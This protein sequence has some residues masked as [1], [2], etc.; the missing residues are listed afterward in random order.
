MPLFAQAGDNTHISVAEKHPGDFLAGI[1]PP[2]RF[3][4]G[5][6]PLFVLLALPAAAFDLKADYGFHD[7]VVPEVSSHTFG[8]NA[9][10][11]TTHQFQVGPEMDISLDLFAEHDVDDL[12]PDHIPV[13]WK[14]AIHMGDKILG[15][16]E[17]TALSWIFDLNGMRNTVSSIEKQ[18]KVFPGLRA[19]FNADGWRLSLQ[20]TVGYYFMEIDDD[21][22][23]TFGYERDDL[24]HG[25]WGYSLLAETTIPIGVSCRLTGGLQLWS[26]SDTWLQQQARVEFGFK[27]TESTE[28]VFGAEYNDY[29]LSVYDKEDPSSPAYHPVLP[30]PDDMLLRISYRHQ[31]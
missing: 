9:H 13:W 5:F 31:W 15:S 21:V 1:N 30:T 4:C 29:N 25:K 27:L 6:L 24:D 26:E 16:G 7:F 12:D 14:S 28:L 2:T 17:A 18:Y 8:I 10:L 20:A 23:R 19:D 22:P 11:Q 3:Y